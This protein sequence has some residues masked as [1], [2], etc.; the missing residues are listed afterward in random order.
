VDWLFGHKVDSSLTDSVK[1][2][3]T[4]QL[5]GIILFLETGD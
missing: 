1:L 3:V 2:S 4:N 5:I